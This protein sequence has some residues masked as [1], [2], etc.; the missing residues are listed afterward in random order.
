M[1]VEAGACMVS[2]AVGMRVVFDGLFG[3]MCA[4]LVWELKKV[5]LVFGILN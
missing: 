5:R 1:G 2:G 3:G 4:A